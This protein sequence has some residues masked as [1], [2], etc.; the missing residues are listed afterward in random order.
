[1]FK[2]HF[3]SKKIKCNKT[4]LLMCVGLLFFLA[5]CLDFTKVYSE[6]SSFK[7]F[8][9]ALF[10]KAQESEQTILLDFYASWCPT[11]RRQKPVLDALLASEEFKEV[12]PFLVDYDTAAELKKELGVRR[13]STLVVF[14]GKKEVGRSIGVTD[15]NEL[16]NLIL[17]G[18]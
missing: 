6:E 5:T 15:S 14:K 10:A 13:Q 17:G 4:C 11:C 18:L 9:A 16:R 3:F 8:E 2:K 12:V 7:N 1:M